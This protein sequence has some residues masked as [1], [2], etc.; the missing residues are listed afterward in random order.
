MRG[1]IFDLAGYA[2]SKGLSVA[3]G[4]N[5]TLVTEKM[6]GEMKKVPI[7]RLSVSIDFPQPEMQDRFRGEKGAFDS[8]LSGIRNAQQAGLEVQI[9]STIT[10][11]NTDYLDE[12][13]SMA[14]DMRAVAFHPFLLVPTGRGKQLKEGELSP[15]E[16]ERVFRWIGEKEREMAEVIS[17]RPTC[18]PFYWRIMHQRSGGGMPGSSRRG[19]LAGTGFCFVSHVGRVQG[20]GYLDIEAGDV[21][22]Q[23]F[24]D[25]WQNSPLFN[26]LRDL[27]RLKGSCGACEFKVVC[28][29]CR[30]RAYEATGD[31][32]EAEPYCL[33]QP[34]MKK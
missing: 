4:S 24:S 12:L 19:C 34:A 29:G 33:Y 25:I 10:R 21:R 9:N 17:I 6:A 2:T 30:A 8:A 18:A 11:M 31:Y 28:G 1:D 27:S 23:S 15:R 32:L 16:C 22:K 20:C 3:V 7:S 5:G 14:I 26:D 13:L